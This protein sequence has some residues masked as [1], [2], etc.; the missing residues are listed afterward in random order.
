MAWM[1][2]SAAFIAGAVTRNL[3]PKAGIT[4]AG[5]RQGNMLWTFLSIDCLTDGLDRCYWMLGN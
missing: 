2:A 5:K 3:Y 1:G 4:L